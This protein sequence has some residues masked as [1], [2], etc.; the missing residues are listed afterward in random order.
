[1]SQWNSFHLFSSAQ[2]RSGK[3][4]HPAAPEAYWSLTA[5]QLLLALH[6]T[7]NG[8]KQADAEGRINQ[9]GLNTLKAQRCNTALGL[10]L[11]QFKSPLVLILI[12]AA[13][14]SAFVREWTDAVIAL[15]VRTRHPFF[16]SRPGTLLLASTLAVVA[17][18][19]LLP[20]L[21]F[22]SL[23]GFVPLPAPLMLAMIALTALYVA[24]TEITKKYFYSRI[25][26]AAA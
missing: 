11:S 24:I 16:R 15:V 19:L 3:Q 20:Y 14:V 4:E 5:E 26:N 10:F 8:L 1:M 17:L 2:P 18:T 25:E 22:Q 21:P 6:G 9:Y 23:F 13:T 7:R 12:F